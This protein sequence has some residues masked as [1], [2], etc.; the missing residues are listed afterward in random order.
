MEAAGAETEEAAGAPPRLPALRAPEAPMATEVEDTGAVMGG[1]A[2]EGVASSR[3]PTTSM[4]SAPEPSVLG[5]APAAREPAVPAREPGAGA[6]TLGHL[7]SAVR[8]SLK[9]RVPEAYLSVCYAC[10]GCRSPCGGRRS[11][12]SQRRAWPFPPITFIINPKYIQ[13]FLCG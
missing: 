2:T 6:G 8:W 4:S 10:G 9:R 3:E 13:D 1:A 11:S 5:V 12:V 7:K